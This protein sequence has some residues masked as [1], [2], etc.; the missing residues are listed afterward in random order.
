M[1]IS[2]LFFNYLHYEWVPIQL[3][4]L[5]F[6]EK[7]LARFAQACDDVTILDITIKVDLIPRNNRSGIIY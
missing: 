7:D 2:N 3:W 4:R 5:A 6:Q 1:V